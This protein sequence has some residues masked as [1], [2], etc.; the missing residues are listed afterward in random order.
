MHVQSRV[1]LYRNQNKFLHSL[2][3]LVQNVNAFEVVHVSSVVSHP[4]DSQA[5]Q[6][7]GSRT[8]WDQKRCGGLVT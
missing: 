6:E 2:L 5:Q 8:E 4:Y 3:T 1:G 7:D